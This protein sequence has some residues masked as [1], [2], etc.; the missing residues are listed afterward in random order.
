M[1]EFEDKEATWCIMN[2]GVHERN[3]EV[4]TIY[5]SETGR[6]RLPL[7]DVL[8]LTLMENVV[9]RDV[10]LSICAPI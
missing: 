3:D 4:F 8:V 10:L 5:P 7:T 9:N 1:G 6:L 2:S